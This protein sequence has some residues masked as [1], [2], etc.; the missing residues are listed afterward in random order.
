MPHDRITGEIEPVPEPEMG[1]PDDYPPF[2]DADVNP[3][4]HSQIWIQDAG[5]SGGSRTQLELPRGAH[6]F[7]GANF[8]GYD[9][10][11]VDHAA[12]TMKTR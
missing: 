2:G 8:H 9:Y 6:R 7:F 3:S 12:S 4:A 5:M 11:H 10:D 1:R